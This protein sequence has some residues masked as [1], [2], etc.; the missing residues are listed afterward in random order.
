MSDPRLNELSQVEEPFL[1]QL[2]RLGWRILRGDKYDP[3]STLRE[4]FSEVIIES[5]L[6]AGLKQINPFLED[7]QIS[8][9]ARRIQTPQSSGLLKANEEIL[10]LLLEGVAV[11]ENRQTREVS[12]TVRYVDFNDIANNR[13][14]A[15]SQ[16]KVNVPG[17]QKHIIPDIVLFVN[18]LPL[19]VVECKSPAVAD[20]LGEAIT[21]LQRYA[22]QRGMAEG[23]E[24]LFWY[25]QFRVAT[26]RQKCCYASITGE[27]DDFVEWKD[28]YPY[29][30]S[31]IETEG[32]EVVNSQQLLIQGMLT[33]ENLLD[34]LHSFI[35]FAE[36]SKRVF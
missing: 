36:D 29:T 22:N 20:P 15:V 30:L 28:P 16:F 8:E 18:G 21:Q 7:D 3:A 2:E 24:K 9:L 1:R 34:I 11:S 23:N 4:T 10:S 13:L 33:R 14:L 25:N 31:D 17:T 27:Y 32:S 6:R 26:F 12:P 35:V 5:E 19:V